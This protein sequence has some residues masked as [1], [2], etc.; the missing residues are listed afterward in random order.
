MYTFL[1][2]INYESLFI[3]IILMVF[4]D[5][6]YTTIQWNFIKYM[7]SII[8]INNINKIKIDVSKQKQKCCS[9]VNLL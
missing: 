1:V 7:I 4:D 8:S 6:I 2:C 5:V 9:N 3:K